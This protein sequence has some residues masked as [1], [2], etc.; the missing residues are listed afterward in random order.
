MRRALISFCTGIAVAGLF[1]AMILTT[2][3]A[4]PSHF[5]RG[6][7]ACFGRVYDHAFLAAHPGHRVSEIYVFRDFATGGPRADA[8]PRAVQ[9]AAD[10]ASRNL[11]V[12][13][14][15][16]LRDKAGAYDRDVPC[17]SLGPAGASCA[18]DCEGASFSIFP[19]GRGL[20]IDRS[21]PASFVHFTGGGSSARLRFRKDGAD[22]RLDPMPIEACLAA[23]DRPAQS[24]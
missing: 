13:V 24:D 18:A 21:S 17:E 23:Y 10:R 1:A 15:A 14:M 12:T 3:R 16:R 7:E 11:S 8:R 4:L 6:V 19:D 22:Y 9:V 5:P 20:V 2:G